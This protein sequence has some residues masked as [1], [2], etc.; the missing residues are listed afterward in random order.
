MEGCVQKCIM[1]YNKVLITTHIR[2]V[3]L[4]PDFFVNWILD[5]YIWYYIVIKQMLAYYTYWH[6]TN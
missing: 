5:T 4:S 1:H 3:Q 6:I 2:M